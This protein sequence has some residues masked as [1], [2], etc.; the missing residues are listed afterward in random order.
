MQLSPWLRLEAPRRLQWR[1]AA[2]LAAFLLASTFE[3]VHAQPDT[4][5]TPRPEDGRS[6]DC[7]KPDYP[8]AAFKTEA[9]GTT[10]VRFEIDEAGDVIST[11]AVASAGPTDAHKALDDAAVDALR[12]C[13]FRPA[14]GPDGQPRLA[15]ATVEYRWKIEPIQNR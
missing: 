15:T 8:R 1:R 7:P 3:A 10:R 13:R 4:R 2:T 12:K 14:M 6:T 9:T 5:A 11:T